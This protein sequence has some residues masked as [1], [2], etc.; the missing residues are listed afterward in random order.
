MDYDLPKEVKPL[1]SVM[2][3]I[4]GKEAM[5]L[6]AEKAKALTPAE[7]MIHQQKSTA[8][9]Y[10]MV[11]MMEAGIDPESPAAQKVFKEAYEI[12]ISVNYVSKEDSLN[13]LLLLEQHP[14]AMAAYDTV[15]PGFSGFILKGYK[16]FY[17]S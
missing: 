11:G 5:A 16:K 2:E 3:K 6:Y 13:A 12:A 7:L 4:V 9:T 10:R 8:V 15:T 14:E 17:R 1:V